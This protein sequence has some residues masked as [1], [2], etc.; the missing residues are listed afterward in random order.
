M[1]VTTFIIIATILFM[2]I[3]LYTFL[4]FHPKGYFSM[5]IFYTL[6]VVYLSVLVSFAIMYFALS[7]NGVILVEGGSLREIGVLESLAHSL[8]FSGVTLL[9]VGYGDITPI[10][11]GRV[12]A[13]LEALIGYI[14]PAAFFLRVYQHH[15]T[16]KEDS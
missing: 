10:G 16:R 8:Y 3:S 11:F 14:L 1:I 5:E 15:S 2:T 12:L 7:F 6:A 9:T 13:L 4:H